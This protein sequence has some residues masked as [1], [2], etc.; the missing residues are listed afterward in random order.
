MLTLIEIAWKFLKQQDWKYA[1]LCI[2]FLGCFTD[3]IDLLPNNIF[4]EYYL[5]WY[6]SSATGFLIFYSFKFAGKH[7]N[8]LIDQLKLVVYFLYFTVYLLF[9]NDHY[10]YAIAGIFFS[11]LFYLYFY[12]V[13]NFY[14]AEMEEKG[15]SIRKS[16]L[17]MIV[18]I[19]TVFSL[20]IIIWGITQK[21]EAEKQKVLALRAKS[22]AEKAKEEAERYK[23]LYEEFLKQK[24]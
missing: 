15:K 1:I 18:V 7:N 8:L 9:L 20:G 13:L 17:Y 14:I 4:H 11:I 10:R 23:N 5:A 2:F 21:V 3:H 12:T 22:E 24:K 6:L 16:L 19:T